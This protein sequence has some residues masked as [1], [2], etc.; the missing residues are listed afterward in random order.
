MNIL[1]IGT[2]IVNIKRVEKI[3]KNNKK[4]FLEKIFT[5]EEIKSLKLKSTNLSSTISKRFAAKEA[6]AK[7]MGTGFGSKLS[8]KNIEI[9]HYKSGQPYIKQSGKN[10]I[11]IFSKLSLSDD[12][13]WA[14][15]FVII[16]K[17]AK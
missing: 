2:D 6:F 8:F 3:L 12:Y 11:K 15:A 4:I 9:L 7:A 5:K 13:P 17:T 10:K 1:G 16:F 14:L